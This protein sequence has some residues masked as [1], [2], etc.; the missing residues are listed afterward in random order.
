MSEETRKMIADLFEKKLV[1]SVFEFNCSEG[2]VTH[3]LLNNG[4]IVEVV[5]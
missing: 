5:V 3:Y 2:L 1:R 4:N